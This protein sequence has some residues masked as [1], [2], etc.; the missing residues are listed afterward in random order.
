MKHFFPLIAVFVLVLSAGCARHDTAASQANQVEVPQGSGWYYFS[1]TGI[2]SAVDPSEIPARVFVP[3]TQA[4]RVS[5]AAIVNGTPALLI[6]H[7]GL[8]T[9]TNG[10]TA[11]ALHTDPAFFS[12]A[13]AGGVYSTGSGTAIRLYRN[14]FFADDKKAD[15]SAANASDGSGTFLAAFDPDSGKFAPLLSA[16]DMGLPAEAQCVALDRIGSMWYAS[17]KSEQNSKVE[18]TYL[19]FPALPSKKKSG[20][21]ADLSGIRKIPSADY[22]QS[23]T[24]FPFAD[25]PDALKNL[26]SGIP[27]STAFNLRVRTE[28]APSAENYARAGNGNPVDGYAWLAENRAAA[29]FADGTFYLKEGTDA[30]PCKVLHLPPLSRGYVYTHFIMAGKKMIAAWE[31][32]R[33]YETGRAGLLEITIPDAVY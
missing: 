21:Q 8:M 5:D 24:P 12:S 32:Q 10:T 27:E 6:N 22:Q 29:L 15:D 26:L 31:E 2:H 7:L 13:T 3:W 28:T 16:E 30:E 11:S 1:D 17:F 23:V 4:V 19:E 18:F 25:A 20:S 14:T 9:T 33:F